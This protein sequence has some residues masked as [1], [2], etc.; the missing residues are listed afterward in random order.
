MAEEFLLLRRANM[1]SSKVP[2]HK[3]GTL[4]YFSAS[5]L[6]VETNHILS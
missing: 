4:R 3:D 6:S 1:L 2:N 5:F